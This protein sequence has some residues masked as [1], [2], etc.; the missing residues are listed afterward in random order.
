MD[1]LW[2]RVGSMGEGEFQW[3]D[4]DDDDDDDELV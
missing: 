2:G 3:D 4:D 1:G